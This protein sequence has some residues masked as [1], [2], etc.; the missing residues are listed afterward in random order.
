MLNDR[1]RE[2]VLRAAAYNA[3]ARHCVDC[4]CAEIRRVVDAANTPGIVL[5]SAA[6]EAEQ[7][8]RS[9]PSA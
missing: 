3:D 1:D 2:F 5:S 8:S 4:E 7:Q 6:S 9:E